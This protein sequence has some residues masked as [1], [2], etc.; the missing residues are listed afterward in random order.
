MHRSAAQVERERELAAAARPAGPRPSRRGVAEGEEPRRPPAL[1]LAGVD[2]ER[3]VRP[4]A[5]V[6]RRGTCS[7]RATAARSRCRAGRTP[8]ARG[9]GSSGAGSTAAAT[10][11]SAR[12]RRTRRSSPVG[13]SGTRRPLQ[14]TTCRGVGQ[15]AHLHLQ[16]LDRRIDVAG[17]AA[18]GRLLAEDVPRLDRLRSS[19]LDAAV[20][21]RRRA[22][23]SGTRSAARTTPGRAGSRACRSSSSTSREVLRD[24][25]RQHEPVVQLG[26]PADQLAGRTASPRTARPAPRSRSCCARLIRACGGI[27]KA[28][29]S[30]SPQPAVGGVRASTACRCRTR[31]GACCRS[32]RSAGG[33]RRGRPATAGRRPPSRRPGSKAISSS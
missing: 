9:P 25:V 4:P 8:A 16:P 23:G 13:C 17:R 7:R 22:A 12:R 18:A 11:G 33:G 32:R 6:R 29:S 19:R 24:E 5:G 10:P 30:T 2:R 14:V 3:L 26:A 1:G 21:D 31:P 28:R 27:S 15:P 20:R